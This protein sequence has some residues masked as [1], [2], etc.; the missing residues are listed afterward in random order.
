MGKTLKEMGFTDAVAATALSQAD[1][2]L[3]K[4][5]QLLQEEPDVVA[6]AAEERLR[7]EKDASLAEPSDEM[8]A[9]VISLGYEPDMAR[10]ALR[11]EGSVEGA[12][13]KLVEGGGVVQ[14]REAKRRRKD[15]E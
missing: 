4:A 15:E 2:S 14:D 5:V 12:V 3:N 8:V 13:E 9:S 11:N 1:N 10:L 6:I 7:A